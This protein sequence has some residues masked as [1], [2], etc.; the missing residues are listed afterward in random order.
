ML[1]TPRDLA[2]AISL[3]WVPHTAPTPGPGP[4]PGPWHWCQHLH[5]VM[6]GTAASFC[7]YW[8]HSQ[9]PGGWQPGLP[10][11]PGQLVGGRCPGDSWLLPPLLSHPFKGGEKG[12]SFILHGCF[13]KLPWDVWASSRLLALPNTIKGLLATSPLHLVPTLPAAS[14]SFSCNY[15]AASALC[16]KSSVLAS[17]EEG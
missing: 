17:L 13:R 10:P 16:D 3:P 8:T 15:S 5:S 1:S 11:G 2:A 9:A 4:G 7:F 12:A 6:G 14:P